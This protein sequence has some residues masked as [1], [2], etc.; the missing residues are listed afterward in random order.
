MRNKKKT[1]P[2]KRCKRPATFVEALKFSL[3]K[4]RDK[5][6]KRCKR[7]WRKLGPVYRAKAK[8][9]LISAVSIAGWYST[10]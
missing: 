2:K 6:L 1:A 9:V 5:W 4:V 3:R 10:Q 8:F 7:E